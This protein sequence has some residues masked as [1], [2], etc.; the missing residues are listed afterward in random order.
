MVKTLTGRR[1]RRLRVSSRERHG[2]PL[3]SVKPN[4]GMGSCPSVRVSGTGCSV[5]GSRDIPEFIVLGI[6]RVEPRE[7]NSR[8]VFGRVFVLRKGGRDD[9]RCHYRHSSA[10]RRLLVLERVRAASPGLRKVIRSGNKPDIKK[11]S[12]NVATN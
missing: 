5:K 4:V 9:Y 8:P 3:A 10:T 6:N 1:D 12:E 11:G 2:K 7:S